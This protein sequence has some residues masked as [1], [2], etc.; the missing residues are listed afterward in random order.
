ME[1]PEDR[2]SSPP[3][4]TPNPLLGKGFGRVDGP[5]TAISRSNGRGRRAQSWQTAAANRLWIQR[6]CSGLVR[7][8]HQRTSQADRPNN[9]WRCARSR[10]N[11]AVSGCT[12]HSL[13][14]V[15]GRFVRRRWVNGPDCE[16]LQIDRCRSTG[17][18]IGRRLS[19][20]AGRSSFGTP[21]IIEGKGST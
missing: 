8:G 16:S 4:R 20:S 14:Y 19:A 15:S 18:S 9:E 3:S 6:G 13:R 12:H 2:S 5:S 11:E 10:V 7:L 17:S 21:V 1:N